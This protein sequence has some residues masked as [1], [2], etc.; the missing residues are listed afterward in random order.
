MSEVG[1]IGV[2]ESKNLNEAGSSGFFTKTNNSDGENSFEATLDQS[3]NQD[4]PSSSAQRDDQVKSDDSGDS[5]V[6]IDEGAVDEGAVDE[7][8]VDEEAVDEE[9]VDEEAV[10]EEA[11]DNHSNGNLKQAEHGQQSSKTPITNGINVQEFSTLNKGGISENKTIKDDSAFDR[12]L[13]IIEE[14]HKALSS[15]SKAVPKT[16]NSSLQNFNES[17][18]VPVK[19]EVKI[20]NVSL[21]EPVKNKNKVELVNLARNLKGKEGA[22]DILG[23]LINHER[24]IGTSYANKTTMLLSEDSLTQLSDTKSA[25]GLGDKA[26]S[27]LGDLSKEVNHQ[28]KSLMK[29]DSVEL[30]DNS[31]LKPTLQRYIQEMNGFSR[32]RRLQIQLAAPNG[33]MVNVYLSEVNGA[34]RVQMS[35]GNEGVLEWLQENMKFLKTIDA[36]VNMRWLPPQIEAPK[37]SKESQDKKEERKKR[38]DGKSQNGKERADST[39]DVSTV[40]LG[41]E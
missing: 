19:D 15:D 14:S 25:N 18:N 11:V 12:K 8:A 37:Q 4:D 1:A 22:K 3:L 21:T 41:I 23:K 27:L 32:T 29:S 39:Q 26:L 20:L 17:R 31:T 36:G 30:K 33:G 28:V 40:E 35:A 7:G 13:T 5:Q 16:D 34:M 9:A 10:D 24:M 2:R 6:I 38:E